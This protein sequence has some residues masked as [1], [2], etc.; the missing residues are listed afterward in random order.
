[1]E[2]PDL[3]RIVDTFVSIGNDYYK[4]LYQDVIPAIRHMQNEHKLRWY[5]FLIHRADQL[6]GRADEGKIYIHLRFE[7]APGVEMK[8]FIAQLPPLFEKPIAVVLGEIG[9]VEQK[10]L[11]NQD[12]AYAWK[13]LGESSEWIVSLFDAHVNSSVPTLN[14]IQFMHYITNALS[15]GGQFRFHMRDSYVDF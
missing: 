5:S 7:P 3:T 9:G 10:V 11:K 13:M 6:D 4:R 1:M 15:L 8:D 12:W 2:L 14:I